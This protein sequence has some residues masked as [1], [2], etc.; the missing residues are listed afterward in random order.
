MK[1]I[2][3][4]R[5][6][7]RPFQK[8]DAPRMFESWCSD[9]NVA[10][11]C[12]WTA[13]K[14]VSDTER[15]LASYLKQQEDGFQYRWAIADKDTGDLMGCIDVVGISDDRKTCELGYSIGRKYWSKGYTTEAARAVIS[16]LFDDGFQKIRAC[17]HT[18]NPASGKVMQKLGMHY[19]GQSQHQAKFD[20]DEICTVNNYELDRPE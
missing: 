1:A 10:R 20:S 4:E 11:Y 14:N 7:L 6:I 13:H 17:H 16:R 9:E 18:D 15:L 3:T 2:E 8:D 12:R 5:L 19:T